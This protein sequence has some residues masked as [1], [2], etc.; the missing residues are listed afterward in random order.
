MD[1]FRGFTD[2]AFAPVKAA[3]EQNFAEHN[4]LGA[5]LVVYWRGQ[6]VVDLHG[7]WA[8]EE[9][10][11]QW[12]ERSV[13]CTMSAVKGP[14]ALCVHILADRGAL[15]LDQPVA[16]VWPG[17]A[18]AGKD[19]ITI[20][21]VLTHRA[22]LPSLPD[23][24]LGAAYNWD[25]MVKAL[26]EQAPLTK[27]GKPAYHAHTFG[28]LT[29]E[30][31]RRVTGLMP[32]DFFTREVALP[33]DVDYE[34]VWREHHRGRTSDLVP[35]FMPAPHDVHTMSSTLEAIISGDDWRAR[36]S[37]ILFPYFD[38]AFDAWRRYEN[39]SAFGH[40]SARGFARL[41]AILAEGGALHGRRLLST[42]AVERLEDTHW[43]ERE[44]TTNGH[45]RFGPGFMQET[46]GL[47]P[48]GERGFGH[49]GNG[50]AMGFANRGLR[51]GFGYVMNR[52]HLNTDGMAGCGPRAERLAAK[53]VEIAS[54]LE[55]G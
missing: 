42:E 26:E 52:R 18:Q 6:T 39:P 21:D 49:P 16:D 45:W 23:A 14:A 7:G 17:F 5:S 37:R 25:V 24:P 55:S 50:G 27:S 44:L 12:T 3:F 33:F 9:R 4:E 13:T 30:I 43:H 54:E 47:L 28:Y 46:P 38:S 20:E 51:L 31:V 8:N 22:G 34:L 48:C 35:S 1:N 19:R 11:A 40:G 2:E 10:S 41:Y 32:A 29:G 15:D 36:I 53:V